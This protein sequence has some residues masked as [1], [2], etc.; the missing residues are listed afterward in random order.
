MNTKPEMKTKDHVAVAERAI[1]Q[2]E[3]EG[4][5]PTVAEIIKLTGGSRR[6]MAPAIREAQDRLEEK[7]KRLMAVPEMPVDLAALADDI[8]TRAYELCSKDFETLQNATL[9]ECARQIARV[10]ETEA[11]LACAEVD[12]ESWQ[13]RAE[14]AEFHASEMK[15]RVS[16]LEVAIEVAEALL[17]ERENLLARFLGRQTEQEF[18]KQ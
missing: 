10:K 3:A 15:A 14:T 4:A 1:L 9:A 7:R 17:A 12:A 6:E 18:A 5:K 11:L 2:L 8:W 13:K 16:M